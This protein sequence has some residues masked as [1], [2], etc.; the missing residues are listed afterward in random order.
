MECSVQANKLPAIGS[1]VARVI[2]RHAN[3]LL[4]NEK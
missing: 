3:L 1:R 4:R 2:A